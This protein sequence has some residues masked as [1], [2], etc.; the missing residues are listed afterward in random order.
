MG[1]RFVGRATELEQL[2]AR[3]DD[4]LDGRGGAVL[5]LG[6]PGIGKS[7][8]AAELTRLAGARAVPVWWGG[9]AEDAGAPPYWPW[10]RALRSAPEP[11]AALAPVTGGGARPARSGAESRFALFDAVHGFLAGTAAATGLVV[12]LD[13]LQW[14][15]PASVALLAH[16]AREARDARLLVVGTRRTGPGADLGAVR[17][18]RI[19]LRGLAAADVAALLPDVPAGVAAR[20]AERAGGNPFFA[21]ELHRAGPGPDVPP[22]VRDVVRARLARLPAG[23]R[24]LL[25]AAAVLGRELDLDLLAEVAGM[26]VAEVDVLDGL[27]PASAEG[28][29]VRRPVLRFAHDLVREAVL[30]D[31]DPTEHGRVHHRA[32]VALA[33]R[34]DDPDVVPD[35]ARHALAALPLGDRAA[36]VAHA[37]RAAELATAQLAHEDAARMLAR[38]LDA[39]RGVLDAPARIELLLA[40]AGARIRSNDVA[41]AVATCSAAADL[42]RRTG[43]AEALGRAALMLPGVSELPW[44]EHAQAWCADALAALPPGDSALR[45]RLESQCAHGL[46]MSGGAEA[47]PLSARALATAERL[48]D[49][50]ALRDALRARQLARSDAGGNAERLVLS[51]RMLALAARTGDATDALWGHLWR[52]DALLQAG[53]VVEGEDELD[54][55]E[56]VVARLRE[57]LARLHLLRG[58]TALALG[59]GRF[60]EAREL[61]DETLELAD[62]GGHVGATA[63]ARSMY[64][65]IATLTGD[66]PGDLTWLRESVN[67]QRA[68]TAIARVGFAQVA[69]HLGRL[70]EARHWYDGLPE[71]GTHRIPAFLRLHVEAM[72]AELA[73]ALGDAVTAEAGY[74]L[75]A[76]H[77]ALHVVGGAGVITTC[78]S[79]GAYAGLAALAAGRPDAAVRLLRP[80]VADNEATGLAPYAALAR[81]HL[82]RALLARGRAA[83]VEEAG[84]V[85]RASAGTADRLGMRPLQRLLA[86]LREQSRDGGVLSRRETGI[87][88]LVAKGLTNRQIAADAGISER[89]V[90]T[91]VQHVLAK[92]GFSRRAEIAAWVARHG[93]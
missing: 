92:L 63:T 67:L 61:N 43:D 24:E 91:H 21:G 57:P 87:A 8:L 20:I 93:Q 13:D 36:A 1:T 75:L 45:S 80:A 55:V 78:G 79:V 84:A 17:G 72:R 18:P 19:E 77:A 49:V 76:P 89:T 44:L 56:P 4:A 30:A 33:P 90:E 66:D 41:G 9:C 32:A 40:E 69:M 70:D 2:V 5:L 11:P 82:A 42:A 29:L 58:R 85:A 37:R 22:A 12:V 64:L 52:F 7:R 88:E 59:R 81:H 15:D 73:A 16:V 65:I 86:G 14:A 35:L 6:E 60:A 26:D 38:A 83:D 74:R 34:A 54:L 25:G 31:V 23:C 10:R 28:V 46:V 71:V 27:A 3:L 50:A 68:F 48:D 39:G 62:R 53:R 47:D 51:G